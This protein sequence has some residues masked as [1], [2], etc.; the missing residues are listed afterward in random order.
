MPAIVSR[1][2][3]QPLENDKIK[4]NDRPP[5]HVK[6]GFSIGGIHMKKIIIF[7]LSL[8]VLTGCGRKEVTFD[9]DKRVSIVLAE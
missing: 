5:F 3:A 4:V 2:A 7:F 9:I 6:G 8:F 1:Q